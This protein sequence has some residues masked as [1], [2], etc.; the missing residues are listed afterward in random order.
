MRAVQI[1]EGGQLLAWRRRQ[2]QSG[3]QS[4]DLDWLLD[5]A[6]G[7][8][9]SDLQKLLVDSDRSVALRVPLSQLEALWQ[10]HLRE[11]QPLQ[12]LVGLCP[13]RDLLLEV[14]AAALIPRQETEQ[15][16]DLAIN[17][18]IETSVLRWAD[19]GTGSGAIAVSLARAYSGAAGHAV[20]VCESA[21][22]LAGRNLMRLSPDH[23]CRL[24]QGHWWDPLKPWWGQFDLVLSNPPYI[25][26]SVIDTLSPT[27]RDH[28]PR[29]ALDGGADGLDCIR[30]IVGSAQDALAPGGWLLIE[31][32]HDQSEAVLQLM[33]RAGLEQLT[34]ATDL[35]RIQRFAI[36][37]RPRQEPWG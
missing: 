16:L 21:L 37:Q 23:N 27:V 8:A 24:H 31:H 5:L 30:S 9:W 35:G 11:H 28:E 14:S 20:D 2:L 34:A 15:L 25:P 3:G 1:T 13:W 12:H 36:G 6:G 22:E 10:R 19:L 32:H 29:L 4:V 7:L 26:N 17:L 33:K 18:P